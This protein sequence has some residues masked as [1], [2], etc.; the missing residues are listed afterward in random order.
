M[1]HDLKLKISE[2][3]HAPTSK[4]WQALT[5]PEM[6]KQYFYG[7]ETE[8]EWEEGSDITFK[9]TWQGQE[10]LDKGTILEIEKEELLKYDYWSSMS[11]LED[12]PENY[13]VISY[14]LDSNNGK[15]VITVTQKGFRDKEAYEHSVQG[16]KQVLKNLKTL[17]EDQV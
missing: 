16:W 12:K 4:V 14:R 7:T 13:A 17:V 15:T 9:G 5:E 2:D 10:Y 8:S 11:G 6:I 1:D 3:I